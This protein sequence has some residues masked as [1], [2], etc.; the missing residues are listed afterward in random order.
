MS[1]SLKVIIQF[2]KSTLMEISLVFG[3]LNIL[4]VEG[5]YETGLFKHLSNY[6]S[7]SLIRKIHRLRG[8]SLFPKCLKFDVESENWAKYFEK[9]FTFRDNCI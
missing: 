2:D 8:L 9:A 5:C 7:R 4:T 3:T 6:I 1:A